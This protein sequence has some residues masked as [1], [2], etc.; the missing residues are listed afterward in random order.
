M[1]DNS[2]MVIYRLVLTN[3]VCISAGDAWPGPDGKP[4]TIKV[5]DQKDPVQIPG[6]VYQILFVPDTIHNVEDDDGNPIVETTPSHYKIF[7]CSNAKEG[8]GLVN[9]AGEE[10]TQAY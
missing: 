2:A 4:L 10:E 7:M 5:K 1:A 3:G 9:N 6:I 8:G